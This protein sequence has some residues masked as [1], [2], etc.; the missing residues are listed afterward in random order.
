MRFKGRVE[1]RNGFTQI[2]IAPFIDVLFLL[3]I[4][5]LL[6]SSFLQ[7]A[8]IVIRLP[9]SVTSEAVQ[10]ESVQISL[11]AENRL[12]YNAAPIDASGL[13]ALLELI[14][15]AKKALLIKADTGSSF[16]K[17]AEVWELA[18]RSGIAQVAIATNSQ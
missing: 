4:F 13:K 8:G 5:F 17:I 1:F 12:F 10:Q 18:R 11:S 6:T 14:A 16:G 15:K 3:S 9:K 7:Q 2:D